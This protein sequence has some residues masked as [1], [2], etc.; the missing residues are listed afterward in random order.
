MLRSID[1]E[2]DFYLDQRTGTSMFGE[3]EMI[4]ARALYAG[5]VLVF[6]SRVLDVIEKHGAVRIE[7]DLK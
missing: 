4:Y 5:E 7:K 1:W 6:T 3:Q 2:G